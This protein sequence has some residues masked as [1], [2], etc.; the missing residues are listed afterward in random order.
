[1]LRCKAY[2]FLLSVFPL[3]KGKDLLIR[4]HMRKCARCMKQIA[5]REEVRALLIHEQEVED[6]RDLW[7][8]VR[9]GLAEGAKVEKT[10]FIFKH[11]W[12]L[13]AAGAAAVILAGFL[14]YTSFFQNGA[15]LN[16]L[17]NTRFQIN[18]IRVGDEPAT[19]F[20]YQPKDSDMILVWAEK[21]M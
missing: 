15:L 20:L 1:M 7:P 12:V 11:K 9:S 10:E 2:Q 6:F 4:S 14:L 8:A 18:S 13:S 17:G 21:G 19:P 16:D 5:S 3:T